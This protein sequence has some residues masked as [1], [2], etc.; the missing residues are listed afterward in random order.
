[1][2]AEDGK[3]C[4]T[5]IAAT[6]QLFRLNNGDK[7]GKEVKQSW[8]IFVEIKYIIKMETLLLQTESK[9]DLK[10]LADL[11]KKI[12][13]KTKVLTNEDLEDIGLANAMKQGR[14]KQYIDTEEYLKKLK[15]K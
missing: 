2:L 15:S 6:E 8:C 14:T 10:V 12:G 13:I 7:T 3:I 5:D 11:A 1:M 9:K 4:F